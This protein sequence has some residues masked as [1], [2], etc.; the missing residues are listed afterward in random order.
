MSR[1]RRRNHGK[2]HSYYLTN[3]DGAESKLDGVTTL[4][5]DGLAKPA[6]INWAG[7]T[8]AAYAIDHWDEL[9]ALPVSERLTVLKGARYAN[10]DAAAQRGTQVHAYAEQLIHG[11]EVEVPDELR[12]H[13]EAA[14][15]W[16]DTW[17]I[18]PILT[19]TTVYSERYGYAGTLDM[20]VTSDLYPGRVVLADYKTSRSGIFSEAALQ[21][22]AYAH[23]DWYVGPDGED[24]P[25]SE[26]GIDTFWGVWVRADGVDVLPLDCSAE[27]FDRFRRIAAV[28]RVARALKE[29]PLVGA[30][31]ERPVMA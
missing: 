11:H 13:V 17:Q 30:A 28:A 18:R 29:S 10:L 9:A 14:A 1:V 7:N 19:E 16:L 20:V 5:S 2:S 21:L 15:N 22:A 25:V 31:L 3:P 6:L 8:T 26:L 4:L 23:A 27:T 12:G 24:H